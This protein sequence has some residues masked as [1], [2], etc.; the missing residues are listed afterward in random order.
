MTTITTL[1][2]APSRTDPSTF[3]AKSDALLGALATFVSETNTVAGECVSNTATAVSSASTATTQA[4]IATT[5]A[6]LA[7]SN[8]AA[9]VSLASAQVSLA[10]AQVS[11]ATTQ[12]G[13]ATT[14]AGIATTQAGIATSQAASVLTMDKR[15]LGAFAVA[16]TLDNQG[17]ALATG[18]VYYDT[19]LAKVETWSGSAWVEGITSVAGVTTVNGQNGAITLPTIPPGAS[20]FTALN[21]GGF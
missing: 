18:A 19:A 15:Y 1:P 11:L 9:Q 13:I 4:G 20:I 12:A 10:A 8:G 17:A 14:Q 5:Q 6:G 3:S 21:F 16:P 2:D 7:T